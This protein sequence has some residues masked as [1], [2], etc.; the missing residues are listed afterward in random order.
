MMRLL[1]FVD[2]VP[3]AVGEA[4]AFLLAWGSAAGRAAAKP[5]G[6]RFFFL[7]FSFLFFFIVYSIF[8]KFS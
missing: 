2:P 7:F 8:T 1:I 6:T 5:R 3:V 4:L